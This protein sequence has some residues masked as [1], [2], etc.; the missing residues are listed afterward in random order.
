MIP[1]FGNILTRHLKGANTPELTRAGISTALAEFWNTLITYN[2]FG[3]FFFKGEAIEGIMVVPVV[4]MFGS[5][6]QNNILYIP[7]DK[8]IQNALSTKPNVWKGFFKLFAYTIKRSTWFIDCKAASFSTPWL[9]KL[10]CTTDEAYAEIFK[11]KME[12]LKPNTQEAAMKILSQN[13]Y[14]F[15]QT[16]INEVPYV[17]T[18]AGELTGTMTISFSFN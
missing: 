7:T 11:E 16:V 3:N 17:G 6:S 5:F 9:A 14:N 15:L 13:V 2:S 10:D 1:D 8:E 12:G 4:G 18:G